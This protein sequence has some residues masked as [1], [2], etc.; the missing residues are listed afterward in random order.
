MR[1]TAFEGAWTDDLIEVE[2]LGILSNSIF[3]DPKVQA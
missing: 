3:D 1:F 2:R